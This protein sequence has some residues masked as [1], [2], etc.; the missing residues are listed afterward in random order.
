MCAVAATSCATA[1]PPNHA[2]P[3][4]QS[5][6]SPS[7]EM[8]SAPRHILLLLCNPVHS[9]AC[10]ELPLYEPSPEERADPKL[11]AANVRQQMV[12]ARG[13]VARQRRQ[14]SGEREAVESARRWRARG[15]DAR[16]HT[17]LPLVGACR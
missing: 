6:F 3:N 4:L 16:A 7:W 13:V 17:L 8:I 1:R 2:S 10:Y 12:R 11:Y 9:V 15:G 5:S 14:G